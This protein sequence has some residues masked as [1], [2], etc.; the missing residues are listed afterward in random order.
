MPLSLTKGRDPRKMCSVVT[1][2]EF[3]LAATSD[4]V[5]SVSSVPFGG[6]TSTANDSA[7]TPGT[8]LMA[9]ASAT[10]L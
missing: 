4:S 6:A 2:E 9:C 10:G 7:R 3:R 1:V 8:W 5:W